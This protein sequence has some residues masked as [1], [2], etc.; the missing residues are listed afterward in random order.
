[1]QLICATR[2]GSGLCPELESLIAVGASPRA[3]I[4]L[5]RAARAQRL[6]RRA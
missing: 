1:M 4:G 5:A 3:S 6:A 2:P